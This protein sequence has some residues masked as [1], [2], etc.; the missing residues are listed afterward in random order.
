MVRLS[1]RALRHTQE[2]P[3]IKAALG[4]IQGGWWT[5]EVANNAG[6]SDH[7]FC[8]KCEPTVLGTAMHRLW[9]CPAYREVRS[10]LS[11][12]LSPNRQ[13]LGTTATGGKLMWEKGLMHDPVERYT[14]GRTHDGT[15]HV[16][17]HPNVRDS[18]FGGKLF[19][20]GSLL[21]KHGA[22]GGQAGWAVAQVD[23]TTHEL[24]CSAHGAHACLTS[25]ATPHHAGRALGLATSPITVGI[26]S[27]LLL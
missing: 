11:P 13:H 26:G 14:P 2:A 18:C 16:W 24:V 23:E 5:Q 6:A 27:L 8:L 4:V 3:A 1:R 10:D 17:I 20:D 7:P 25:C 9:T 19:V 12:D 15:A 22:Q 21:S